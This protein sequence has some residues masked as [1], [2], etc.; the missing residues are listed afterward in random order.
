MKKELLFCQSCGMPLTEETHFGTNADGGKNRSYCTY[1]YQ[2]GAFTDERSMEEMIEF[3]LDC[4]KDSGL[5]ADRE[6]GR[7]QMTEWF[8]TLERWKKQ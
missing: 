8:P 7:R 2:N 6:E 3:Y 5:Y 1:C 4:T